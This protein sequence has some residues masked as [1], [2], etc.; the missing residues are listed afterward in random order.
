MGQSRIV[1]IR[2]GILFCRAP[3]SLFCSF[4]LVFLLV[5]APAVLIST[6]IGR[7]SFNK[8]QKRKRAACFF[9]TPRRLCGTF[10]LREIQKVR[11][12]DK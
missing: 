8:S 9:A 6:L 12:V 2:R 5:K 10:F 4:S 1:A 3:Q 7:G 11:L